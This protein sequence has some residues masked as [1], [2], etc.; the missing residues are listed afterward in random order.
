MLSSA[1]H[2]ELL[3]RISSLVVAVGSCV[4]AMAEEGMIDMD[5]EV[6]VGGEGRINPTGEGEEADD[7]ALPFPGVRWDGKESVQYLNMCA[8]FF[9]LLFFLRCIPFTNLTFSLSQTADRSTLVNWCRL[10]GLQV[11]G[12]KSVLKDRLRGFSRD[13]NQWEMY[14]VITIIYGL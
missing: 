7:T 4:V 11:S 9:P 13:R 8:A 6:T 14:V 2:R 10:Y 1:Q 5:S 3:L 12:N